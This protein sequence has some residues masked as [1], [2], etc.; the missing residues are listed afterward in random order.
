MSEIS[1]S[2]GDLSPLVVDKENYEGLQLYYHQ[3]RQGDWNLTHWL[4]WRPERLPP[5]ASWNIN[6]IPSC[7]GDSMA[8]LERKQ[9]KYERGIAPYRRLGF[10]HRC[11]S[12]RSIFKQI[13]QML[14]DISSRRIIDGFL[15][16]VVRD[17][18]AAIHLLG[19][20]ANVRIF[21]THMVL[22]RIISH[23]LSS[24]KWQ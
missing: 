5:G 16:D 21:V 13:L 22:A 6:Y 20:G 3:S 17:G 12:R 9:F 14:C 8:I 15:W 18:G 11:Q 19:H 2:D 10:W 23:Y 4:K 1:R 24:F 7:E